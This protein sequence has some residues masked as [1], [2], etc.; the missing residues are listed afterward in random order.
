MSVSLC[1]FVFVPVCAVWVCVGVS[2]FLFYILYGSSLRVCFVSFSFC[3]LSF[4]EKVLL[5]LCV[6]VCFPKG[7][8]V[9]L[10]G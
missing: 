9:P 1:V 5:M 3:L 10:F 8:V 7:A 6:C 2:V 4:L